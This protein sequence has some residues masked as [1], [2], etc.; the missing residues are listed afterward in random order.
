MPT[1]P[2]PCG[3]AVDAS[4]LTVVFKSIS[5]GTTPAPATGYKVISNNVV[6]D[7]SEIFQPVI[8]ADPKSYISYST[9]YFSTNLVGDLRQYFMAYDYPNVKITAYG[10]D[11][12]LSIFTNSSK[13]GNPTITDASATITDASGMI[14]F[15]NVNQNGK[16]TVTNFPTTSKINYF[17]SSG[18][19]NG[20]SGG[21]V[22]SGSAYNGSGGGG[23]G[24]GYI[25]SGK[26]T[27]TGVTEFDIIVGT[28]ASPSAIGS[29]IIVPKAE[30]GHDGGSSSSNSYGQGG[31]G[32]S[33]TGK[34]GSGD[35]GSSSGG[36]GASGGQPT[37]NNNVYP[38]T[39]NNTTYNV[40]YGGGGGGGSLNSNEF[41]TGGN[42]GGGSGGTG[43]ASGSGNRT[44]YP[45][46]L[47][48]SK[49][50]DFN[51]NGILV[52]GGG[53]GGSGGVFG[54]TTTYGGRVGAQGIVILWWQI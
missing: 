18:G 50:G 29:N 40:Y 34:G 6:K 1:P 8:T 9:N 38:I 23:G 47:K 16:I 35:N 49:W 43:P 11:A 52:G 48:I 21:G 19:G 37:N 7:L 14:V 42:Y 36:S 24:G 22:A 12:S 32:G 20:G 39:I 26:L 27:I 41:T 30:N 15:S 5:S 17:I 28:N 10:F 53:G 44:G 31:S 4:D 13:G 45:G 2:S 46:V 33:G 51:T 25:N 54:D 3:Y